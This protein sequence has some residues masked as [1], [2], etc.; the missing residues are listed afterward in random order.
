MTG[1]SEFVVRRVDSIT[2]SQEDKRL[3]RGLELTNG[4][5]QNDKLSVN[6]ILNIKGMK[7]LLVS[8]PNTDK[9]AA[10]MDVNVGFLSDP[11][12]VKGLAHFCEH[13]L[14]LGT[15]KYPNDNDYNKF[16]QEH[17]GASNATTYM[18]HTM[19]YFDIVPEHLK[20]ALDR[21]SA[22]QLK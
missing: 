9:S 11:K 12:E 6:S 4:N 20:G 1:T 19:Y 8:D 16:L 18:D 3:Y 14:F 21:Y 13:M 17:G 10:A 2:K 15:E 22:H 7:V 5:C